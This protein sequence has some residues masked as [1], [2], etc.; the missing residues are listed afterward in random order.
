MRTHGGVLRE[1]R[2]FLILDP[3][4]RA[5]GESSNIL[6]TRSRFLPFKLLTLHRIEASYS[7]DNDGASRSIHSSFIY[8]DLVRT[9]EEVVKRWGLKVGQDQSHHQYPKLEDA[10]SFLGIFCLCGNHVCGCPEFSPAIP[11]ILYP[12]LHRA[13][14]SDH[15]LGV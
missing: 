6:G 4:I 8:P 3:A 15:Q 9:A 11:S 13:P 14:T 2:M 10:F 1:L 5:C 7:H 12:R